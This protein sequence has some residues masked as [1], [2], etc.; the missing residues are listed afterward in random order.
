MTSVT[1]VPDVVL[2]NGVKIPQL[3]F[4]VFQVDDAQ[5]TDAVLAALDAGYRSID[6]AAV[7][8][9]EKGVGRAI[10]SSGVPRDE[11]FITTKLWNDRQGYDSALAA[12]DT[13]LAKLGLDRVD[14]YLIHWPAPARDRYVD[15]WRA[16]EKL[17]ADGRARA[18][19]VSNFQPA[20]LQ[21][22]LDETGVVPV[23]NQIELH[24]G[25]QQAELRDFHAQHDIATEA[26]SPLAKGT[27]LQEEAITEIAGRHE[28]SP[29]QVVLRWHIQLGNIVIPKSVTPARIRENIDVFDFELSPGD[30]A[31]MATLDRGLR[32]GPNPDTFN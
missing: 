25:L 1:S 12:F 15:T 8:G 16:L 21:R 5:T 10:A 4:G 6:T 11:L 7:Y 17:L 28:K 27:L 2:N 26:W 3:G 13:S 20:H 18:I 23:L 24:P 32:T 9:N 22:L 31:A 14:L 30:M 29:A 19:G